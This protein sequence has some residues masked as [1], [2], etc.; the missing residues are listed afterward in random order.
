VPPPSAP[1]TLADLRPGDEVAI[2]SRYG[3]PDLAAVE[4]VTPTGLIVVRG[5]KYGRDGRRLG[6][7]GGPIRI[8]VYHPLVHEVPMWSVVRRLWAR[9]EARSDE[10]TLDHVAVL[11][12]AMMEVEADLP[13]LDRLISALEAIEAETNQG[14]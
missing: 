10:L 14:D 7:G 4:R 9:I 2:I 8:E 3:R 6:R 12:E 1:A 13:S 5:R 11:R